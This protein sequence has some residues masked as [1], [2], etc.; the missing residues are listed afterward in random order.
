MFNKNYG[1]ITM[2]FT[3]NLHK[4]RYRDKSNRFILH[5]SDG[6]IIQNPKYIRDYIVRFKG[7]NSTIEIYEPCRLNGSKIMLFDNDYF[8]IKKTW[9]T[10]FV[11]GG[12]T[13][14]GHAQLFIDE[15]CSL[16]HTHFYLNSCP[17][18]F[19]KLGRDCMFSTEVAIWASDTHQ[20]LDK[21]NK[22]ILNNTCGVVIGNHVWCGTRCTILKGARVSDNSIIGA[23]S[24]VSGQFEQPNIIIAGN[25]AR[26]I[27]ENIDWARDSLPGVIA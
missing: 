5:K 1:G 11:M 20:I 4:I 3:K 10:I 17:G 6:T 26:K 23:A 22:K 8:V 18:A 16:N 24:V 25:P 14:S 21:E 7:K 27:K 2:F 13:C 12:S 9:G 15:G 19:I